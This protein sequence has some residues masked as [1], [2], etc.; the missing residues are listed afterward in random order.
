[1][2]HFT[3]DSPAE[4]MPVIVAHVRAELQQPLQQPAMYA[5]VP[6]YHSYAPFFPTTPS[7]APHSAAWPT[8]HSPAHV[9]LPTYQP[10]AAYQQPPA[11][12]QPATIAPATVVAS[13]PVRSLS[14]QATQPTAPPAQIDAPQTRAQLDAKLLAPA[15]LAFPSAAPAKQQ[16]PVCTPLASVSSVKAPSQAAPAPVLMAAAQRE[17]ITQKLFRMGYYDR[18]AIGSL[19]NQHGDNVAA[20]VAGL[21]ASI[22]SPRWSVDQ[23]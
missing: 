15:P 20:I 8:A 3:H 5:G 18:A 21:Q 22:A 23:C 1:M 17:E 2:P 4:M 19:I 13:T 7:S 16:P 11:T 12:P 10:P 6:M 14:T 9:T